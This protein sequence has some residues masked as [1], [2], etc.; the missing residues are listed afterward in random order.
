MPRYYP[1][2]GT[3]FLF[4]TPQGWS[5]S[6]LPLVSL[7]GVTSL[8]LGRQVSCSPPASSIHHP[9]TIGFLAW[10]E[11]LWKPDAFC[12]S[13]KLLTN[14][15]A[16]AAACPPGGWPVLLEE[17]LGHCLPRVARWLADPIL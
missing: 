6:H 14:W 13:K 11:L 4:T 1:R 9:G 8:F 15:V 2:L 3:A 12:F 17:G 5:W 16:R 7:S 10:M